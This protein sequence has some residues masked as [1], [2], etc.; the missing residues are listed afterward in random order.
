MKD[1]GI[2]IFDARDL[3]E[4]LTG[5]R[6]SGR[7]VVFLAGSA[8]SAPLVEGGPGSPGVWGVVELIEREFGEEQRGR[9]RAECDPA[10]NP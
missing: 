10:A 5:G 6:T 2:D 9:L 7:E 1:L 4:R 3:R 8:L